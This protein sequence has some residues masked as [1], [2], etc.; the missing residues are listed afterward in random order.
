MQVLKPFKEVTIQVSAEEYVTSSTIR[1]L[2]HYLTQDVLEIKDTDNSTVKKMKSEMKK[3]IQSRYQ[4]DSMLMLNKACFVDARFNNMHVNE[5]KALHEDAIEE[6]ISLMPLAETAAEGDIAT[7]S[8][9]EQEPCKK[10]R[11]TLLGQLLGDMFEKSEKG[12]GSQGTCQ[13]A[14]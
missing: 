8:H 4:G 5:Q 12:P 14:K 9:D 2:L 7:E 10:K 13:T 1:P 11:K 3:N 6:M